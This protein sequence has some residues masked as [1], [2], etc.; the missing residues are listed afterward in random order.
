MAFP[1]GSVTV[2]VK[3]WSPSLNGVVVTVV[4]PVSKSFW[5]TVV[6]PTTVPSVS[7]TFT[8]SPT[9]VPVGIVTVTSIVLSLVKLPPTLSP[10][11][12][13][14]TGLLGVPVAVASIVT[15]NVNGVE[16]FPAV[17]VIV[18]VNVCVPSL[19]VLTS[20]ETVPFVI[21]ADVNVCV[22][23][24]FPFS[25]LT[26][27]T[28]PACASE[29]NV[30]FTVGVVSEVVAPLTL[31]LSSSVNIALGV[32]GAIVSTVILTVT[33]VETFPIVSVI[34]IVTSWFPSTNTVVVIETLLLSKSF[35]VTTA[36]PITSPF[37]SV[38]FTVS[39]TFTSEPKVTFTVGVLSLVTVPPIFVFES[40]VNVTVGATGAVVSIVT[41]ISVGVDV[42]PAASVIVVVNVWS[43][44]VNGVTVT[45]IVPLVIS[46][47]VTVVVPTTF[48]FSS[49]TLTVSPTLVPFGTV[50]WRY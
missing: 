22:P 13:V 9:F 20:I 46:F 38:I 26:L 34:V 32:L 33:G 29:G 17:S 43:P 11:S 40:S 5:V 44:S 35:W 24:S 1:I 45:L 41:V 10:L 15:L 28:S 21:S 23:I 47:W 19:N 36:V 39:P 50:I 16:T 48:P 18:T 2:V 7:I 42:L 4:V 37:S 30:T 3:E 12:S 14:N 27:T 25:S 8:V 6:V 49:V 31:L